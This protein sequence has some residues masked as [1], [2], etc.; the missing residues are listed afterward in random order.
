MPA[1]EAESA[2]PTY[3]IASSSTSLHHPHLSS[4]MSIIVFCQAEQHRYL[5]AEPNYVARLPSWPLLINATTSLP[6]RAA[7]LPLGL[8]LICVPSDLELRRFQTQ[9]RLAWLRRIL[10]STTSV[11]TS[12][13]SSQ[14]SMGSNNTEREA[15][16]TDLCSQNTVEASLRH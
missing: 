4:H 2:P 1:I 9:R 3:A 5:P 14:N 13:T 15:R 8:V 11:L 16:R 7:L 6:R 10:S 12:P